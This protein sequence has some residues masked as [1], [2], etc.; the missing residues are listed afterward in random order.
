MHRAN[1]L[2]AACG[3]LVLLA[4]QIA[5]APAE[6]APR[7]PPPLKDGLQPVFDAI[8]GH[9]ERDDWRKPGWTNKEIE[10]WLEKLVAMV[11]EGTAN[12][13]LKLP[14]R[15]AEASA[16]DPMRPVREGNLILGGN[17]EV[18]FAQKSIILAHGT[19]K[20]AHAQDCIIVARSVVNVSHARRCII[21]AG[22]FVHVSHDGGSVV[23]SRGWADI[24]HATGSV[25]FAPEG[26]TVS[27]SNASTF[28]N[29]DVQSDRGG[30]K[31]VK[32]KNLPLEPLTLDPLSR[33]IE[34]LGILRP[35]G[36]VFRHEGKRY[37]ASP[38][39]PIDDEAGQ[40]VESLKDWRLTYGGEGI[41]V[42]SKAG[43]EAVIR[44]TPQ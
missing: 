12:P 34:V 5:A 11:R 15:L 17:V 24:S 22:C 3:A 25:I 19:A 30:S 18:P 36:V 40:P 35:D 1:R 2:R 31:S 38:G 21:V 26:I 14:V 42:F 7:L 32:I 33:K 8:Q 37:V 4:W 20:V 43:A 41:V 44:Y 39:K 6:D 10:S 23:A 16:G 9:V 29:A 27:H 13:E 28:I